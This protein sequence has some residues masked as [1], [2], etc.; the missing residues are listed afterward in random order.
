ML[1]FRASSG[2]RARLASIAG[3]LP[4]LAIEVVDEDDDAA[5]VRALTNMEVLLHVLKPVTAEVISRAPRLRLIQKIGVGVNTIALDAARARGIAVCNMP[6]SNSQAVAE[7]TLMLM[8]ATLRRVLP[9]DAAMRA[10]RGWVLHPDAL[11]DCGELAGRC[12]GLVGYGAVPQRLAPVLL[13][14]GARVI[15]T[16][17][18]GGGTGDTG[19]RS[20]DAL[21]AEADVVSLHV[22]LTPQTQG[23]L[24]ADR[25]A[26]MRRGAI[27]VN[28][29][30]G[31][32]VDEPALVAAL[33]DRHLRAA[34]LDVFADEPADAINPLLALDNV[35][36]TP[37]VAWL[38]PE[39]LERSLAIAVENCHRLAKGEALLHRMA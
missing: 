29:A 16:S 25:I 26:R 10:G 9:L 33:R 30:R 1:Q 8:L 27:L 12:V 4:D 34:G 21:L 22:P 13:A 15:H 37:H 11:D 6:G 20:L 24:N 5:F 38:T 28:T 14:L 19:W 7:H 3:A 36:T 17:R 31:A 23:M 32:L 39:T 2:L 35:V 18:R